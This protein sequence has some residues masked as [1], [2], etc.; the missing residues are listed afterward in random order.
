AHFCYLQLYPCEF[1]GGTIDRQVNNSGLGAM[2][3]PH[4]NKASTLPPI[5]RCFSPP[6]A[7]DAQGS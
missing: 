7:R 2:D 3:Q 1:S 6:T 4:V 5:A